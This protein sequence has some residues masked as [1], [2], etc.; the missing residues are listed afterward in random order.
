VDTNSI[1]TLCAH[2]RPGGWSSI[3]P[4]ALLSTIVQPKKAVAVPIVEPERTP[5]I[6]LAALRSDPTPPL[7]AATWSAARQLAPS[8]LTGDPDELSL[9]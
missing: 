5:L 4:V 3:L 9:T 8:T 6:G 7:I 1:I 2:I